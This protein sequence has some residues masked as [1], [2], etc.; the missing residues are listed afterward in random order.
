MKNYP[1]VNYIGNKEKLADWIIENL[2][3]KS[4]LVLDLF[5]GGCSVSY[6]LKKAG[7]QVHCNDGL[8]SNFVLAKSLIENSDVLLKSE[9]YQIDIPDDE[10]EAKYNEIG[11]I[12]ENL[13]FDYEVKELAKLLCVSERLTGSKKYI[14]LAL[15]RRAMIRKLPYS[16]MN[17]KWTE[18]K[19]L[20]DEDFSYQKYGRRRAYHNL[21]FTD[22]IDAN[23][24]DYNN[25]IFSNGERCAAFQEDAFSFI[26]DTSMHYDLI[27][28]DPPY[29]GT[30]NDYISFYGLYDKIF[31]KELE[32]FS[33]TKRKEF[34]K[35]FDKLINLCVQKTDYIA[36]SLNDCVDG[37]VASL[38]NTLS[39][40]G[41]LHE[42]KCE[43]Q[44]KLTGKK[45]KNSTKELLIVL[46]KRQQK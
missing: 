21:P 18:I 22:H 19:K 15:L 38:L 33:L 45:N 36:I 37:L 12:K 4:G 44:Y 8:Y 29:P 46:E 23:L 6:S 1:K 41:K 28:L 5:C 20:R 11:Y 32:L 42:Y 9:D 2:P 34:I 7:F 14:F 17:I 13:Y 27:Y 35:D 39:K 30:L 26:K 31:N 43:H 16:R 3:I 25:A 24:D 10:I 40:Y